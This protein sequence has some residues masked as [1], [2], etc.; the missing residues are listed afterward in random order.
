MNKFLHTSGIHIVDATNQI[1]YLKGVGLGNQVWDNDGIPKFHHSEID[2]GRIKN[3]GMNAVRFYMNY[4][5]FENDTFPYEDK[6]NGWKWLDKN[7]EWAKKNNIY[8]ILNLHIAHGGFQSHGDGDA[9]WND[10]FVQN[11]I[12]SFWKK[13][14]K[15]Y[16][17]EPQIAG[18]ALLNEP[19]PTKSIIQWQKLAQN[20]TDEI[21]K[22]DINHIII[23]ERAI[24]L[25][26]LKKESIDLNFPIVNDE[27]IIYEFHTF[28][29]YNY[30]H[31]LLEWAG[32]GDEGEYPNE[33]S[34]HYI[35]ETKEYDNSNKQQ[36]K[37]D[38]EYLR[39]S[40]ERYTDWGNKNKVP[41]YMGEFGTCISTFENKKGGLNWV[42]DVL[43][44][45]KQNDLSY[46][47]HAYHEDSYGLYFGNDSLP[48]PAN[49]NK[50]L[51]NLFKMS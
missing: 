9:I 47:Y 20:I 4:K 6:D 37:R 18:Y 16:Q 42:K 34:L 28:Q 51:I 7:I 38:K 27:N 29:P 17:N 22:I 21:R 49:S 25:K 33:N 8:L 36:Y 32:L 14:A 12:I 41:V 23:L 44:I 5:T 13:I 43:D 35:N 2:F 1:I 39:A 50:E 3:M 19:V 30:T 45:V 46:T 48:D 24:Y 15:R 10:D 26:N 11:R 31:Q 40:I